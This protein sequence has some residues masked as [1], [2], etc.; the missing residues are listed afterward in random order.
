MSKNWLQGLD[1]IKANEA[2]KRAVEEAQARFE[3]FIN[4]ANSA[5]KSYEELEAAL[6]YAEHELEKLKNELHLSTHQTIELFKEMKRQRDELQKLKAA[7]RWFMRYDGPR[8]AFATMRRSDEEANK[9][10]A[11]TLLRVLEEDDK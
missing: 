3:R 7:V 2:Q 4:M 1:L 6:L 9:Q 8:M 10:H 5:S 11:E